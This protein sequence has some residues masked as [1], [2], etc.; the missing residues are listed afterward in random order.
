[1]NPVGWGLVAG[2]GLAVVR[3]ALRPP[4]PSLSWALGTLRGPLDPTG[5]VGA[6]RRR[7][8]GSWR[9]DPSDL[10]ITGIAE[11]RFV[12][13]VMTTC[14]GVFGVLV[15]WAA[16]SAT[17]GAPVSGP[18]VVL[19]GA[20]GGAVGLT[21]P[22][23]VL[24]RRA[25]QR[26]LAFGHALST[27]LDLVSVLLAGGAGIETSL[28]AAADAGD[29]WAFTLLRNELIRAR[30][31]RH[32]PWD[33][34]ADLGRRLGVSELVDLAATVRLAGEHGARVR[35]SLTT[36]AA[37]VRERHLARVEADAQAATERM[38]LP[39]VLVFVGF[40]ALLGYPALTSITGGL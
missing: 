8:G 7:S 27:F 30:T 9:P 3:H 25:R 36:R 17:L 22:G 1:M 12:A 2:L 6:A 31:R 14:A 11:A 20:A 13:G 18:M 26:R 23:A 4:T 37:A 24:R 19:G 38:G 34:L 33:G 5:P 15:L 29:G 35:S 39:M 40:I 28:T 16:L 21:L 32:T 10:A